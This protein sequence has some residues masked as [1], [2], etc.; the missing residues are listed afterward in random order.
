MR[1]PYLGYVSFYRIGTRQLKLRG[2]RKRNKPT[3]VLK[4][5]SVPS[6]TIYS[7]NARLCLAEAAREMRG[8][9]LEEV[10]A[11]VI[12]KCAG[13]RYKPEDVKR[14]EKEA[15]YAR[16]DANIERMRRKLEELGGAYRLPVTG[17][18]ATL[19]SEMFPERY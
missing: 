5:K 7:L 17:G 13:K 16:A 9:T 10:I 6:E 18:M 1:V 11:N 19:P 14:A 4:T 8:R 12:R 3:F 15:R 2:P